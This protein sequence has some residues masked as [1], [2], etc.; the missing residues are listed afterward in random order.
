M[1]ELLDRRRYPRQKIA[2]PIRC[3]G[4]DPKCREPLFEATTTNISAGGVYV[5]CTPSLPIEPG[6]AVALHIFV[7]DA[8]IDRYSYVKFNLRGTGIVV[9]VDRRGIADL[10]LSGVAVA[11][12]QHLEF[13]NFM[14]L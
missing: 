5:Q 2:L 6:S 10:E 12:D 8:R 7:P 1:T 14:I 9:R 11:F 4:P 13:D 3:V